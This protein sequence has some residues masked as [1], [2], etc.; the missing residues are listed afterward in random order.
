VVRRNRE[1]GLVPE[2]RGRKL[3]FTNIVSLQSFIV[4]VGVHHPFIAPLHLQSLPYC[5]TVARP[6]R[7]TRPPHRPLLFCRTPYNIGDGNVV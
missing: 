2:W 6:L 1:V 7:N 5:N 4:I 3:A